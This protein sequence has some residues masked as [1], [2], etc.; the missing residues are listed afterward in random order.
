MSE[1]IDALESL[2]LFFQ[3]YFPSEANSFLPGLPRN[4]IIDTFAEFHLP[5]PQEIADL[6]AWRNGTQLGFSSFYGFPPEFCFLPLEEVVRIYKEEY[7]DTDALGCLN[8]IEPDYGQ[9]NIRN[10]LASVGIN[11]GSIPVSGRCSL[12]SDYPS[13]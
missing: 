9:G 11:D 7:V 6:Y 1:L 2:M 8:T 13:S 10:T 4:Q 12:G 5:C 3:Q